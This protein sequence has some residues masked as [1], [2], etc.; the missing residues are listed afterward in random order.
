LK[1]SDDLKEARRKIE[2]AINEE[3]HRA[4]ARVTNAGRNYGLEARI[5][6]S[7]GEI[8]RSGDG[9]ASSQG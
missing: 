9:Q 4:D 1:L 5:R 3:N 2:I 7:R 6:A 8:P